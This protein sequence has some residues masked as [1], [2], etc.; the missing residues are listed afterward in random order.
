MFKFFPV[1]RNREIAK[2]PYYFKELSSGFVSLFDDN[3]YSLDSL[4]ERYIKLNNSEIDIENQLFITK[5]NIS[6]NEFKLVLSKHIEDYKI[7]IIFP[8]I[9]EVANTMDEL[10]IKFKEKHDDIY[11]MSLFGLNAIELYKSL[12]DKR[13]IL[14]KG[15]NST[16]NTSH[17]NENF[18]SSSLLVEDIKPL[19]PDL[20]YENQTIN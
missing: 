17:W 3:P 13:L 19:T 6:T 18:H 2:T 14:E 5:R 8:K 12:H 16:Q 9:Q 20:F 15:G 1:K 7:K 10:S 11:Y 4:Y